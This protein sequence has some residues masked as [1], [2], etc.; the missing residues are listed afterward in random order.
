M[1]DYHINIFY[2]ED[3]QG[4]IA[5]IPDLEMCSAFGQTPAEALAKVEKEKQRWLEAAGA[6]GR[7]IPEPQ[8][9]P[10]IYTSNGIALTDGAEVDQAHTS[11]VEIFNYIVERVAQHQCI[12]FLGSAIHTLP[13][14]ELPQ[15][16][17]P[18]EKAP[19]IASQLSK[20]LA[21]KSNYPN[22][23]WWNLQ[24][25]AQHF[26]TRLF[27]SRLVEEIKKEVYVGREPSEILQKLADLEFPIVIT[28][29]YDQ[30]YEQA[31]DKKAE[32]E[33]AAGKPATQYRRSV[34]NPN[35]QNKT[36]TVDC[37][38]NPDFKQPYILKIHGDV[39][40]PESIVLTDEDYIQFVLR[41]SDKHPY[42]PFGN[43]IL[44]HLMKWPTLFIGYSLVD[45]NL[46]LLFKTLR[47]KLD[48]AYIPPTYSVDKKPDI[49]IRDVWESQRR[50]V[51]FIVQ[52]LWN[53][54]PEL[55]AAVKGGPK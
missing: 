45:Y 48:A 52:N 44:A 13:P 17:Y 33:K 10:E 21:E 28:T 22:R 47:W 1:K 20:N 8:Y 19:P 31:L 35:T 55:H 4:Y 43:N 42:H 38:R 37:L 14:P 24:R 49:L 7:P 53:F 3:K 25:V 40:K 16:S 12:L 30:L 11:Y 2:Q 41:M 5:D 54:V 50:Y 9:R 36:K 18:K 15:Y 46:R 29:N 32:Q 23:D 26:E 34:Y 27:R 39:D 51:S 6:A